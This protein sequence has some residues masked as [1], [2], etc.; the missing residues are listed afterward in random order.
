MKR[1]YTYLL[2]IL[3]ICI[4]IIASFFVLSSSLWFLRGML[5][6]A[7]G[8]IEVG[9]QPSGFAGAIFTEKIFRNIVERVG[10]SATN[11]YRFAYIQDRDYEYIVGIPAIR[12]QFKEAQNLK[13]IGWDV[14]RIGWIIT[15]TR[16]M[17]G[18][19]EHTS[20][21]QSKRKAH[22]LGG[23]QRE[24][25][26]IFMEGL[27][28]NPIVT[29]AVIPGVMSLDQG[30]SLYATIKRSTIHAIVQY[31]GF[32]KHVASRSNTSSSDIEKNILHVAI[33]RDKIT[34]ASNA[35][36]QEINATIAKDMHFTKTN[37]DIISQIPSTSRMRLLMD[38][39]DLAIGVS[40]YGE[41]FKNG[42]IELM[43]AEQGARHP[44]KKGFQLPDGTIG[45]E[46]IASSPSISF[47]SDAN[48]SCE[49]SVGYDEQFFL[50]SDS[51]ILAISAS[52]R[53]A[54]KLVHMA[55][56]SDGVVQGN[57]SGAAA[58][59]LFSQFNIWAIRFA[60][61]E[62]GADIWLEIH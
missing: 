45:Y 19:M 48:S 49:K 20:S 26:A 52:Q 1:A 23:L 51:D 17:S 44:R 56:Q 36:I 4:F 62:Y 60:G 9:Y 55:A 58:E 41:I 13:D 27:P 11:F 38:S 7:Q 3:T 34:T 59:K 50:C 61:D 53:A 18:S 40:G 42:M 2:Y 57:I 5:G 47:V 16:T 35:F 8:V 54:E 29:A 22:F 46:Y 12:G 25:K 21:A 33:Q 6:D 10:G 43:Q 15:A 30:V 37:P 39:E 31:S 24:F 32:P 14:S 28:V